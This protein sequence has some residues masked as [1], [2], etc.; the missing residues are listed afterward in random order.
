[1]LRSLTPKSSVA[2]LKREAKRWLNDVRAGDS[3]AIA[4]L[5]AAWRD[6]LPD[7]TLRDVQQA[8]AREFGLPDWISLTQAVDDL[9]LDRQSHAQR[10]EALLRHGWDGDVTVARRL[11]ARFPDLAKHSVFTA[12]AGGNVAEVQRWLARDP[13]LATQRGGPHQWSALAFV[14]YS[15]IDDTNGVTIAQLLLDAGADPHFRFDDGWG[16]AFTLITGAIGRGEGGKP[17]HRQARALAELF[18]AA[19]ADPYDTQALYNTSI[20]EDEPAWM[21]WMWEHCERKG[22]T[23]RWSQVDDASLGGRYKVGTL[24]YLL[25]NAVERDHVGRTLW[26]LVHG[27]DANTVHAYSGQRL[28]TVARLAGH[29]RVV[30]LLEQHGA[31]PETLRGR[32]AF[33]AALMTGDED[34]VRA[35]V[36]AAPELLAMPVVLLHAAQLGATHAVAQ[37]LA[38]GVDAN[39]EDAEGITVLH[40]AVQSGSLDMVEALLAAGANVNRR[41][42]K[43]QGSALSWALVL[44]QVHLLERLV[45]ISQD[46]RALASGGFTSRLEDV[47]REAPSLATEMVPRAD[48]PTALFCLPKDEDTAVDVVRLLLAHGADPSVKDASG[49][50]AAHAA[51]YRGLEDAARVLSGTAPDG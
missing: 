3:A 30:A 41:E 29:E 6:A 5:E 13:S 50:T 49:D 1:M 18:V 38:L 46:V 44:H 2:L 22:T 48:S 14:A 36:T 7:P 42:R 8:L 45:P 37:L 35:M 34:M 28:H 31:Q 32:F 11:V 26:L 10:V 47:L 43:W 25:G 9:E 4:R 33:Q 24:N 51:R 19:G 15:R 40:R 21:Q 16:N 27:A 17:S 39:A 12:A 23:A 20:V